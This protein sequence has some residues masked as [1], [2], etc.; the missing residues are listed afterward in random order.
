[1]RKWSVLLTKASTAEGIDIRCNVAINAIE[2]T[3]QTF[4]VTTE[5]GDRYE[6]GM[7]V[8]GAGRAPNIAALDL[9]QAGIKNERHGILVDEQM[10][11]TNKNVYAV[12]D[13]AATIQLARVADAEA[14]VAAKTSFLDSKANHLKRLWITLLY[15]RFCSPTPNMGW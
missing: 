11:T 6:A 5:K 8:N 12:G 1:M 9:N 2:K 14:K 10:T 13:C 7:I 3:N 15:H 4:T